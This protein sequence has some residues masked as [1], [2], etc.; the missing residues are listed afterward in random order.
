MSF[1]GPEIRLSNLSRHWA[2][3]CPSFPPNFPGLEI[4]E[5]EMLSSLVRE[6]GKASV[7]PIILD[8]LSCF[9]DPE[10]S[11]LTRR[12]EIVRR[13]AATPKRV[14]ADEDDYSPEG[15]VDFSAI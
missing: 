15:Y 5:E 3:I 6:L 1:S 2:P 10:N 14:N 12:C 8:H 7:W 13:A 11:S 9:P 4:L